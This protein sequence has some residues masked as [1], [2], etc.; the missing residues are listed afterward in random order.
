[1]AK[2]PKAEFKLFTEEELEDLCKE[3]PELVD[4][5]FEGYF[6][7]TQNRLL[8]GQQATEAD[9]CIRCFPNSHFFMV[10]LKFWIRNRL[11]KGRFCAALPQ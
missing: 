5:T 11:Q 7:Q 9:Q 10:P 3:K 8:F 2:I 6:V 1:M 4:Y